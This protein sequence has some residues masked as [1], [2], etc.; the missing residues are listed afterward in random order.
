MQ[1]LP[2]RL[3]KH[4]RLNWR[5]VSGEV[6]SPP[7]LVLFINSICNMKCEHCFY[8][9]QLNQRD[10]LSF[11]EIKALSEDLGEI[12]N[13][14]LSGGEPFIRK[15]F[16]AVC[17]QFIRQNKVKEIYT[18][19]NAY[20]T[21]RTIKALRE[22]LEDRSLKL[23][24]VELS[25]DGMP[26][27]HDEFRKTPNSFRKA[28]E[29]YDA[30]A[31]LQKEDSRLQIHAIST[32]TADNM[33]EIR[34]LTT[35]LFD[36][37]PKMTHHNLAII[38]GDRKNPTLRGPALETYRELYRYVRR[39]WA[40]RE[41]S[42]YG[43]AVEPMLQYA[44]IKSVEMNA[45]FA[46]CRAGILTGVVHA[47]G[48]V[49]ICEQRPPIGNLRQNSFMEIWRSHHA[50][51]VRRSI[52]KKECYCTNEIFMWPSVVYQPAELVKSAIGARVWERAEPLPQGE[53]ANYAAAAAPLS[54]PPKP[55]PR[56]KEAVEEAD[57]EEASFE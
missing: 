48:D 45:Q 20:F 21:D 3:T 14:N 18:P 43:A 35:F 28:M 27:F 56:A 37:C 26:E 24:C 52:A 31:E 8:W 50:N 39:L 6:K 23:F 7:F 5:S 38:R 19:T 32:A 44:K 1:T 36:R 41:E 11:E 2:E 29:T 54:Q 12:E 51:D 40:P 4:A 9:Q 42:R 25:L 55:R 49:G 10:D 17:K 57:E 13:L 46:P 33:D 16:A 53:R 47:N 34:T 15:D 22:V 30:L